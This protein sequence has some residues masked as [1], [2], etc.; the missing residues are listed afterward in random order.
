M[1]NLFYLLVLSL[2]LISCNC[3]SS[4]TDNDLMT[5]TYEIEVTYENGDIETMEI[6]RNSVRVPTLLLDDDGC[7]S[8]HH[9]PSE[10]RGKWINVACSVR[11]LNIKNNG[12][13]IIEETST[14]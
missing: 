10:H 1:K 7:V 14:Y 11:K 9:R 6:S 5:Y 4:S 2:V 3:G 8:L 13:P 12:E